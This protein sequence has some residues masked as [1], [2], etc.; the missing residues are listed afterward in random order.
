MYKPVFPFY[1]FLIKGKQ[2]S[3]GFC[4]D[5]LWENMEDS[6]LFGFLVVDV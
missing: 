2:S 6:N 3:V 1:I 5:T 4:F